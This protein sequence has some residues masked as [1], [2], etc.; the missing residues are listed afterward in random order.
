MKPLQRFGASIPL[1]NLALGLSLVFS[2]SFARA[3]EN[4]DLDLIP[5]AAN[6]ALN[7]KDPQSVE[8]ADRSFQ[9]FAENAATGQSLRHDLLVPIPQSPFGWQERLSLDFRGELQ[10]GPS[11]AFHLSDRIN[12]FAENDFSFG[13]ERSLRNSLREAYVSFEPSARVYLDAGRIN[14]RNGSALGFSPTDYFKARSLVSQASIDPSDLRNNRLGTAMLK[15]QGI[16]EGGSAVVAFAPKLQRS[17]GV[18]PQASFD[19]AFDQTNDQNRLLSSLSFDVG[20]FSPQLIFY[21]DSWKTKG[22]LNLNRGI[23]S[24]IVAYLEW[25]GGP[26]R[27]LSERAVEFGQNTGT[28]PAGTPVLPQLTTGKTFKNDVSIGASWTHSSKLSLNLEYHY[29]QAGLSRSNMDRWVKFGSSNPLFASELWYVRGYA[30]DQQEPW[31]QQEIF[32][33]LDWPDFWINHLD[34]GWVGFLSPFDGSSLHQFSAVYGISDLWT[35]EGYTG[36]NA[37]ASNSVY[38][39]LP[40]Q[41][42][43]IFQ[44]RRYL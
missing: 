23:G 32:A 38:G 44:I 19:P 40:Q 10:A 29:H 25:S 16:W 7:P 33:R 31:M 30:S 13:S 14:L 8:R 5:S 22:G 26:E 41:F 37:G 42:S 2:G 1:L 4:S 36:F 11:W 34:L 18:A 21:H 12:G 20:D 15:A 43:G 9:L 3:D 39:S 6:S 27:T 35:I 28:L 17:S 24:S